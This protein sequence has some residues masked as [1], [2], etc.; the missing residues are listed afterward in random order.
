[1]VIIFSPKI[2]TK[3]RDKK[4][5]SVMVG[6]VLLI[7]AAVV[8]GTIVYSTLKT[9]V[10]IEPPSC[11]GDTSVFIQNFECGDFR[12]I[13]I[14][15]KNN[16]KFNLAGYHVYIS[17]EENAEIASFDLSPNIESGGI[18]AGGAV[19]LVAGAD[20]P[21][22][23]GEEIRST[24]NLDGFDGEVTLIEVIPSRFEEIEGRTT[25]VSCGNAKVQERISNCVIETCL[26]T[27][28][29]NERT[30]PGTCSDLAGTYL[31]DCDQTGHLKEYYC[32]SDVCSFDTP[33]TGCQATQCVE[34][35]DN[36]PDYCGDPN[37]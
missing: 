21:F 23:P 34:M 11:P 36:S 8:M 31:D 15:L 7:A 30:I 27:D 29:G 37:L 28:G 10:P 17:G 14:T 19:M 26:D 22:S 32:L 33:I 24:F 13:D 18:S 2:N 35:G 5:V 4:A 20:N 25:F 12:S 1:M 16:G 3:M 9:Y 6:Y